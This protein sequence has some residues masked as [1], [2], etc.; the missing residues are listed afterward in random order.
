MQSPFQCFRSAAPV[1]A[2]LC[3]SCS[4]GLPISRPAHAQQ[5]PPRVPVYVDPSTSEDV[6]C[7]DIGEVAHL[8]PNGDNFLSVQSGPG[9]K[10]FVE[11]DR[12][13]PKRQVWICERKGQWLG[14]VYGATKDTD[15]KIIVQNS[16]RHAYA[17]P[18]QSGW[19]AKRYIHDFSD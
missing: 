9:G 14:V 8:D 1:L 10:P 13:S 15:C 6:S 12:L 19:V 11:L 16:R 17:G 7:D 4:A 2:M 3:V 18:C 5:L